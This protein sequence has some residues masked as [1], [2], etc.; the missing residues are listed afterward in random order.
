M[1]TS[2]LQLRLQVSGGLSQR[3]QVPTSLLLPGDGQLQHDP[4]PDR[5]QLRR[6]GHVRTDGVLSGDVRDVCGQEVVRPVPRGAILP[7]SDAVGAVS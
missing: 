2:C 5:L 6:G 1:P 3:N 4:V 7:D